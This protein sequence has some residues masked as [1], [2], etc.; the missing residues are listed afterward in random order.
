MWLKKSHHTMVSRL[1][2]VTDWGH[3]L[4]SYCVPGIVIIAF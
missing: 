2:Y 3:L 1:G 4:S